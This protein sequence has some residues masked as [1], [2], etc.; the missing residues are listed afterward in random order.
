ML[1]PAPDDRI[2]LTG[3][4]RRRLRRQCRQRTREH[5]FVQRR[6]IVLLAADGLNNTLISV[7]LGVCR[8][9]VYRWRHRYAFFGEE[10]CR[11][12]T[13][14]HR[15]ARD[16]RRPRGDGAVAPNLSSAGYAG[17]VEG[18]RPRAPRVDPP[19]SGRPTRPGLPPAPALDPVGGLS[20]RPTR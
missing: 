16:P 20:L 12:D 3:S 11:R 18:S 17:S 15:H 2:Q 9:T 8:D 5:R 14:L 13:E 6:Q 4:E 10:G 1:G 19:A 7:R